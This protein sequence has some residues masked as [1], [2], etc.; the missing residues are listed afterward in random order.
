MIFFSALGLF[1]L[2]GGYPLFAVVEAPGNQAS[3]YD[4]GFDRIHGLTESPQHYGDEYMGEG[5]EPFVN[6]HIG[7]MGILVMALLVLG[8]VI[9]LLSF[10]APRTRATR[11]LAVLVTLEVGLLL[12][13]L[14]TVTVAR[15]YGVTFETV[16]F[17]VNEPHESLIFLM[18]GAVYIFGFAMALLL[19]AETRA[20]LRRLLPAGREEA[21]SR[22]LPLARKATGAML[23][24][25]I[26]V[27]MSASALPW[28]TLLGGRTSYVTEYTLSQ[29]VN[30]GVNL[31]ASGRVL[32]AVH[33]LQTMAWAVVGLVL[34]IW[35][36]LAGAAQGRKK[37]LGPTVLLVAALTVAGVAMTAQSFVLLD[38]VKALDLQLQDSRALLWY[39]FFPFMAS[40]VLAIAGLIFLFRFGPLGMRAAG[41]LR[42]PYPGAK[43]P[44]LR[45]AL[46]TI[47]FRI[48]GPDERKLLF[49]SHCD[50]PLEQDPEGFRYC[51]SCDLYYQFPALR[52][53]LDTYK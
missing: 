16:R 36:L 24:L 49:C 19:G 1:A 31:P 32:D 11:R 34:I 44:G 25:A 40:T 14:L 47:A 41:W 37:L 50:A 22:A 45:V 17:G 4:N 43:R 7:A 29:W 27:V 42:P 39:N 10:L 28:I 8:P 48:L 23:F 15:L 35:L 2:Q 12:V 46:K 26:I 3:I 18:P 6:E 5:F 33:G 9:I 51:R 38:E 21:W 52:S 20:E 13:V 30:A 53:T